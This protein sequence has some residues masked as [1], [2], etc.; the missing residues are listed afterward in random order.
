MDNT[1]AIGFPSSMVIGVRVLG[2]NPQDQPQHHAVQNG[3]EAQVPAT[4]ERSRV[5]QLHYSHWQNGFLAAIL[6][7]SGHLEL[8]RSN[9]SSAIMPNKR[10]RFFFG[11]SRASA[12]NATDEPDARHQRAAARSL[13]LSLYKLSGDEAEVEF[14]ETSFSSG[15]D[16]VLHVFSGP[17][18]G[19]VKYVADVDTADPAPPIM[20]GAIVKR[21]RD[22]PASLS[23]IQRAQSFMLGLGAMSSP[24]MSD[25][26]LTMISPSQSPSASPTAANFEPTEPASDLVKTFLEFYE[27]CHIIGSTPAEGETALRKFSGGFAVDCPLSLEWDTSTRSLC[28]LVYQTCI[29]I[30]RFNVSDQ[31]DQLQGADPIMECLYEIPTPSPALSLHWVYHTLFFTSEDE[32]KCTVISRA[33]CFTLALASRWV[34]NEAS[35]ATQLSDDDLNQFPRPQVRHLVIAQLSH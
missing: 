34:L 23:R 31:N 9:T 25:L 21:A 15:D 32:V 3:A 24:K 30:F 19:V 13:T 11:G 5:P 7:M 26:R 18:L 29:K 10:S 14:V 22:S 12:A 17:L 1:P 28:A 4:I 8:T 20:G 27:W 6:P 35:C 2:E 16:H 33:R